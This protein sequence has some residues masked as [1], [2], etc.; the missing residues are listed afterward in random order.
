MSYTVCLPHALHWCDPTNTGAHLEAPAGEVTALLRAW[1]AGDHSV[2]S[3]LFEVIQPDL[4]R[5]AQN[6]FRREA[7]GHTLQPS[8]LLNEAYLRLIHARERD[9]EN[10]RHFFAIAARI[11]RRLLIDHARGKPVAQMVGLEQAAELMRNRPSQVEEAL[12]IDL[13]LD[14]LEKQHPELC[15]IVEMRF[16]LGL[17]EEEAAEAIGVTLRTVQRRYADARRWLFEKLE[18]DRAG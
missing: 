14:D 10:R 7:P 4:R 16:F 5:L 8:A 2:E 1:S 18:S 15:Q 12:A 3:R 11:M 9:W 13:L 17:T 6:F